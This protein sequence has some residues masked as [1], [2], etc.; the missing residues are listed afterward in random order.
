MVR[1]AKGRPSGKGVA[2]VVSIRPSQIPKKLPSEDI[3]KM[4]EVYLA[5]LLL[6]ATSL[7]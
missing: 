7:M 3:I 6:G 5:R 1:T 2:G 4:S